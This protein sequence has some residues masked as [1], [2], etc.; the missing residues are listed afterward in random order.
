MRY[1]AGRL[2]RRLHGGNERL[3]HLDPPGKSRG[4][5]LLGDIV[6]AFPWNPGVEVPLTHT[7]LWE[8]RRMA[9]TFVELGY[10]VDVIHWSRRS[11]PPKKPYALY[12]DL[13]RNFGTN[14]PGLNAD[15]RK[16]LHIDTSHY[17]F[18]NAAQ[19]RRLEELQQRRGIGLKPF[20]LVE[21]N[22]SIERAD[23]ATVLGNETTMS[24]YAFAGKAMYP[25][26]ISSPFRYPTPADKDFDRCRRRFLWFGS[27]GFVHKGLDLALDAF[28][29]MPEFQLT[30]CGPV[31]REPAFEK[32]FRRELYETPNI[33]TVGW[34]DIGGPAFLELA[35]SCLGLIYPSCSEG[36]SGGVVTCMHAGIIP[37]ISD[38]SGVDVSRA[39][40]IVL[41]DCS[42][43]RI[44]EMVRALSDRPADD[45]R[46]MACAAWEYARA[47]HTQE[48]FAEIYRKVMEK[49]L[50]S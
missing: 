49:L 42:V 5:V 40:G 50:G 45:L 48:R 11:P 32:A 1:W 10:G 18:H 26:P 35:R 15:C 46:S 24:T 8:T 12:T 17:A 41:P 39:A 20:K 29:G 13:R 25:I 38:R 36:Q 47:H 27:E 23:C 22:E 43:E 31:R 30:V 7:N 4:T 6:D 16:V 3:V 19:Q 44:R 21:P 33:R 14:A 34:M 9:E 2:V 37:V 28:A